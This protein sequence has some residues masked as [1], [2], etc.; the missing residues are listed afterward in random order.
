MKGKKLLLTTML[1]ATNLV[2]QINSKVDY[3]YGQGEF[4]FIGEKTNPLS[5][6]SY[7]EEDGKEYVKLD[8]QETAFPLGVTY[9]NNYNSTSETKNVGFSTENFGIEMKERVV[10][11]SVERVFGYYV[12]SEFY[13]SKIKTEISPSGDFIYNVL[14]P[15]SGRDSLGVVLKR[16]AYGQVERGIGFQTEERSLLSKFDINLMESSS[17]EERG[18]SFSVNANIE[19]GRSRL[20]SLSFKYGTEDEWTEFGSSVRYKSVSLELSLGEN[21]IEGCKRNEISASASVLNHSLQL[22]TTYR[23]NEDGKEELLNFIQYKKEF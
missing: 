23:T 8:T 2:G 7:R 5:R 11:G 10:T 19:D 22:R 18:L 16:N 20:P 6:V 14:Y 17:E 3:D 1:A 4:I 21:K 9:L 15:L 13:K 12:S